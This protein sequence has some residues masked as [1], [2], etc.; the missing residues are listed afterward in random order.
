MIEKIFAAHAKDGTAQAG[1]YV[2]ARPD[3]VM[4]NDVSGPVT[5]QK[6][7]EIG[8]AQP[9]DRARIVLVA[10]HFSPASSLAS[11]TSIKMLRDFADRFELPHF[12]DTS[13][14]GIEHVVLA[15]IGMV[16]PGALIF[17]ADSH[18]C[19]A[20]ALNASGMGFGSTDLA[21]AVA[22]G[23]LWVRV[24]EAIRVELTGKTR[25]FVTGKDIILSLIAR[26][27]LD[28][29]LNAAL[30]FGGPGLRSLNV[31]ERMA[32]ANMSVEAGAETCVME[33]DQAVNIYA[34]ERNAPEHGA[35]AAD[36]GAGYLRRE[37]IQLDSLEP[38]VAQPPS[39]ANVVP[40]SEIKN[41]RVNQV[42][43]GN[44]SNGTL[45]DLRQAAEVMKGRKVAKGV[46]AIVVPATQ[47]IYR[48]ALREG[49]IEIIAES[50]AS[51][52]V[53]TCGACFGGHMGI[54]AEGEVAVA[55]TNRN[56]RGRMGHPDSKVYL[57]NSWVAAAAAI[58]GEICHPGQ[59]TGG[60]A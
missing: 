21:A 57:A 51:V 27:G 8:A 45:T 50:G 7:V 23:E 3:I 12:Y 22:L 16:F 20:G 30:E 35:V 33:A 9:F 28:G 32:V 53:P 54:L 34:H 26:L 55:N 25:H 24:P 43:I 39:P 60:C 58:A 5:L 29:A 52:S 11:A 14:G 48:Q 44:C 19:T 6:F 41:V 2:W 59:V 56:F 42:Y 17:G 38:L 13:N 31:D 18:T 1:E 49:L 15:Q 4:I 36:A 47:A 37:T 40:V 46:R 10:D